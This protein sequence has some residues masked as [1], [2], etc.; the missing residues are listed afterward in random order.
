MSTPKKVFAGIGILLTV[1]HLVYYLFAQYDALY[2][3][4]GFGLLWLVFV[5]PLK[6]CFWR[7]V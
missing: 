1:A 3:F 2:F 4:L 7:N 5:L 6:Y